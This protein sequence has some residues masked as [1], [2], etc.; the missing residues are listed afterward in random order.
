MLKD[1]A[2]NLDSDRHNFHG[3]G[4]AHKVHTKKTQL[5]GLTRSCLACR[6]IS[7]SQSV[8]LSRHFFYV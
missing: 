5:S 4:G 3:S 6:S 8:S 1:Q 7:S 2:I